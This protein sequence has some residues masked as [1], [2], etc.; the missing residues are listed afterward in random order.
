MKNSKMYSRL[1]EFGRTY[2]PIVHSLL[3]GTIL[4][5]LASSMS[6]PFLAIYLA[7]HTELSAVMIGVIIGAGPLAGTVGGFVGG[8]MSDLFGRR[9]ILLGALFGWAVVF[10]GFALSDS[11]VLFFLFSMLN[12]LCR[13]FYEPVSQALMADLS[14]KEIRFKV[15]SLRYLAINVG[16]AVGPLLGALF[17]ALDSTLP[18]LITAVIYLVYAVAL[19]V[20]LNRFGIRRIEGEQKAGQTFRTVLNVV[21]S[22]LVLRYFLLGSI[23]TAISYSQM[24]VTL[25]QYVGEKFADGVTLFAVMMSVNAVTVV[26]LQLSFTKWADK[27]KP[28]TVLTV[29]VIFYVIGN[30]GF[31][32]SVGWITFIASM[33]VFTFGE[34]LTFPAGNILTDRIAPE[35]MRGAYYGAQ[36]FSNLGHFLGPW[37]GGL[38]L[39]R[40]NGTLLFLAMAVV[41]LFAIVFYRAGETLINTGKAK[42]REST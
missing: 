40:Y 18:F 9:K 41:A 11:A 14:P 4:A 32:F 29:G 36:S 23:I 2:H 26:A 12:G 17:A 3:V 33:I 39:S 7:K 42:I 1:L 19:Y 5:R 27:H 15:F 10:F 8:A 25:S 38:L 16:V 35:G 28:I 21:R 13:S 30:I 37:V 24:T 22:D 20:L 6:L 34:M 31:A